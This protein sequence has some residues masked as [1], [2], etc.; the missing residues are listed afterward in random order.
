[1][2]EKIKDLEAGKILEDDLKYKLHVVE[3]LSKKIPTS[4]PENRSGY[5]YLEL[6]TL[7]ET[8]L[9]YLA[10]A[11]DIVLKETAE[12]FLKTYFRSPQIHI[13]KERLK[14]IEKDKYA[15]K[16]K[17]E[18]AYSIKIL[19]SEYF[20][21]PLHKAK[22][23]SNKERQ[24]LIS[25]TDSERWSIFTV[26]DG[27]KYD[28]F[29]KE[30][31]IKLHN[32]KSLKK[33]KTYAHYWEIDEAIL[34]IIRENRNVVTHHSKLMSMGNHP[35]SKNTFVLIAKQVDEVSEENIYPG[36]RVPY[37]FEIDNPFEFIKKGYDKSKEFVEKFRN[38][39]PQS[40]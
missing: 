10:S 16:I 36:Y 21:K 30:L 27:I 4:I 17:R 32:E 5:D 26:T 3:D 13:V 35:Y 14:E 39:V 6:E 38:I 23:L 33:G 8:C 25:G 40:N 24:S 22:E 1:M 2:L 18:K 29:G 9:F 20:K 34:S 15:D 31:K 19:L 7:M 37:E 12:N 28:V 11:Q